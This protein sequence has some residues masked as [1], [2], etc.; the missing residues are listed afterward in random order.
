MV[1]KN[2]ESMPIA[3]KKVVNVELGNVKM[4][5]PHNVYELGFKKMEPMK[6]LKRASN[7]A[8]SAKK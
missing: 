6:A 4:E 5:K 3:N 8:S 2:V 1:K 7:A